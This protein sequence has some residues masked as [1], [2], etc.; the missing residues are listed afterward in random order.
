MIEDTA[1][2]L[3][4][5]AENQAP[6]PEVAPTADPALTEG[7]TEAAPEGQAEDELVDH[8]WEGKTWKLPKAIVPALMLNADY[9]RKTQ[10]IAEEQRQVETMRAQVNE[11]AGNVH[12]HMQEIGQLVGIDQRLEQFSKVDW[13]SLEQQNP[14]QAQTLWRQRELLKEQRGE[15]AA[16]I[17]QRQQELAL[18]T[19][20]DRA[21][22]VE[23][24]LSD[25]TRNIPNWSPEYAGKLVVFGRQNG[26]TDD[27]LAIVNVNP[28]LVRLLHQARVGDQM[29][30][31]QKAQ[32][33][34]TAAP[35]VA[36]VPQL[37]ARRSPPSPVSDRQSVGEW[38]KSR[39]QQLRKHA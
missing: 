7:D 23:E 24:G 36:P 13:N 1:T 38:M 37:G 10:S 11:F 19:Q 12:E 18:E 17:G 3:G 15:L 28:R 29:M 31:K 39:A 25:V 32:A 9:T 35:T 34:T 27:D 20:R 26:L 8:E 16:T 5:D 4:A 2:N 21:K 30:K 33:A 6:A 22:R 14:A